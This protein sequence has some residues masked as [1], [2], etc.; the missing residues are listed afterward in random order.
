MRIYHMKFAVK[1]TGDT[2]RKQFTG[3][4]TAAELLSVAAPII[5]VE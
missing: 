1:N 5:F 3:S 4:F 2:L